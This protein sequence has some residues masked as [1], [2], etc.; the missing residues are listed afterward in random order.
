MRHL[1]ADFFLV[2]CFAIA[3]IAGSFNFINTYVFLVATA[4]LLLITLIYSMAPAGTEEASEQF[5]AADKRRE[6]RA[7]RRKKL[8]ALGSRLDGIAVRMYRVKST[9]QKNAYV[10]D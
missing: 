7:A 4:V 9:F 1:A 8:A 6:E 5:L 3:A 10:I 2:V